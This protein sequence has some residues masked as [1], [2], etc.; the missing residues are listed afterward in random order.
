MKV[1]KLFDDRML[2]YQRRE[3]MEMYNSSGIRI[4][5]YL[6]K[7]EKK[8]EEIVEQ[9]AVPAQGSG[10]WEMDV[11]LLQMFNCKKWL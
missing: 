2:Q 8:Q 1:L 3:K 5:G 11:L 10:N 7:K 6:R 4:A 9:L